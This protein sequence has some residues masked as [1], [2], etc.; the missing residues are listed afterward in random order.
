V[1]VDR[2]LLAED[3][4]MPRSRRDLTDPSYTMR[5]GA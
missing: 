3:A 5:A 4:S 1:P 2:D